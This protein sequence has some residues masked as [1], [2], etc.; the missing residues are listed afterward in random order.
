MLRRQWAILRSS[1]GFWV[2]P[3]LWLV[4]APLFACFALW[5]NPAQ[6]DQGYALALYQY[7]V[8]GALLAGW[9]PALLSHPFL[10]GRGGEW[11]R[12]YGGCC[13]GST[14]L[15]SVGLYPLCAAPAYWLLGVLYSGALAAG[16]VTESVGL[17]GSAF[18]YVPSP[19]IEEFA[20]LTALALCCAGASYLLTWLFDHPAAAFGG[21][22]LYALFTSGAFFY[23]SVQDGALYTFLYKF[24]SVDGNVFYPWPLRV[25]AALPLWQGPWRYP[26]I[27]ALG[28]AFLAIGSFVEWQRSLL[29]R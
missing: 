20:M 16:G 7:R 15:L 25:G 5:R 14:A 29:K 18:S 22:G 3:A 17:G 11:A 26:L 27:A 1:P 28:L 19:L 6:A 12:L 9:W 8:L 24:L 21:L 2:P 23:G 4:G 13:H 10:R